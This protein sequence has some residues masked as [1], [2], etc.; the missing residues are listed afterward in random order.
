MNTSGRP[1][2]GLRVRQRPLGAQQL[3]LIDPVLAKNLNRLRDPV[4]PNHHRPPGI[5]PDD[6]PGQLNPGL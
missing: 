5:A 4:A 6:V 3:E 1:T 2:H